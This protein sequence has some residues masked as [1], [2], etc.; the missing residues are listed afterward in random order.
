M[1]V[2]LIR[3]FHADHEGACVNGGGAV[4][5]V[6]KLFRGTLYLRWE[7]GLTQAG[8]YTTGELTYP[9]MNGCVLGHCYAGESQTGIDGA[10][11]PFAKVS[12]TDTTSL[13]SYSRSAASGSAAYCTHV[14][15]VITPTHCRLWYRGNTNYNDYSIFAY[16]AASEP[17]AEAT[18][19]A[20]DTNGIYA[21]EWV[22]LPAGTAYVKVFPKVNGVVVHYIGIDFIDVNTVVAPTYTSGVSY[23]IMKDDGQGAILAN[24]HVDTA[25]THRVCDPASSIEL[26]VKWDVDGETNYTFIGGMA[27]R[28]INA[29]TFAIQSRVTGGEWGV[30]SPAVKT[31]ITADEIR[32]HLTAGAAA[33]DPP[34][35]VTKRGDV[36]GDLTFDADGLSTPMQIVPT[37][38][39]DVTTQYI[40][41]CPFPTKEFFPGDYPDEVRFVGDAEWQSFASASKIKTPCYGAVVRG[42]NDVVYVFSATDSADG[43]G[44]FWTKVEYID[45][46]SRDK[47]YCGRTG[48]PFSFDT[49][50]AIV[51]SGRIRIEDALMYF[52]VPT[53]TTAAVSA[54]GL[55]TAT[56]GGNV[57]SDGNEAVT[58]R[59]VCW[60]TSANPTTADSKTTD[61]TGT[62]AFVSS[63]TG[64]APGTT[65]H[66]R[67]YATNSVGTAYGADVE[68]TTSGDGAV[69]DFVPCGQLPGIGR[70]SLGVDDNEIAI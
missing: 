32:F 40:G 15:A 56:C 68:F 70:E 46:D 44:D 7:V 13:Y 45:A 47:I 24:L 49:G 16:N 50:Q 43:R 28:G 19:V 35:Y 55:T 58:A 12:Y 48:L 14:P 39:M 22:T 2:T 6:Y 34:L 26:A 20:N 21:S 27:H 59:G 66:V 17:L 64:L 60:S 36:S 30:V 67:A 52:V 9:A 41:M 65:Y 61:G 25:E 18:V 53:V 69:E 37:A 57:T 54:V 29:C 42:A 10:D 38:N 1:S 5:H 62:G 31:P 4:W 33:Q 8:Y 3:Q 63:I 23:A 11:G 51:T